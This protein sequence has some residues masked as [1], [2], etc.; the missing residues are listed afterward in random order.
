MLQIHANVTGLPVPTC[1]WFKDGVELKI[2]D[3]TIIAF[4]EGDAVVTVKKANI[5]NSGLYKLIVEN[6]C[7]KQEGQVKV[8]VK[9]WCC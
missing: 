1:K 7:G 2:D 8:L 6:T 4:K 3:N 5:N 9:G